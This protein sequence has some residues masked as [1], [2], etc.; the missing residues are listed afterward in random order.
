MYNPDLGTFNQRDPIQADMNPYCYCANDPTDKTDPS[1]LSFLGD[2]FY[3][4]KHPSKMDPGLQRG[5][6][7]AVGVAAGA[8][9]GAVGVAV[10]GAV[11]ASQIAA[12]ATVVDANAAGAAVG[13]TVAGNLGYA[14]GRPFGPTAGNIAMSGGALVGGFSSG[15]PYRPGQKPTDAPPGTL[16][17]NKHPDTCGIVHEIKGPLIDEGVGPGSYVGISPDGDIIVTNPDGTATN[18]GPWR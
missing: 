2:Y 15:G 12:G 14:I 11:V 5:Q 17:I 7:I 13:I 9:A 1:G 8:A 6:Q 3:Y 4:L 18:L 16:P 10:G